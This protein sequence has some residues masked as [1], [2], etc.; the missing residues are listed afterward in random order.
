MISSQ[1]YRK[2]M[3]SYQN[4]ENITQSATRAGV[5]RKTARKYVHGA[6]GTGEVCP[7]RH[8]R[9]RADAFSEVWPEIETQLW[10]EPQLRAKTLFEELLG[11]FSGRFNRTQ[12]RTFERG[13][14]KWKKGA[15][16]RAGAVL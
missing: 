8:W 14:R 3:K 12:R 13:I 4:E 1:Q 6:S 7:E 9:T 11:Q 16:G 15:Q 2:L 5:D 10:R